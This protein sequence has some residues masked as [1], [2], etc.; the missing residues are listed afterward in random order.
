MDKLSQWARSHKPQVA[1]IAA[2]IIVV[3]VVAI[4][5]ASGAFATSAQQRGQET[6]TVDVTLNVTADSGWDE[7]STPAIAHIEGSDVDFYHA[8]TPD[9]EGNKGTSTVAL[10]EGDYTVS[11]VSPVNS[12]GSAFDIYDTGAPVDIT[13]DADAETAPAVDCPMTQIPADQ[14]TDEMLQD[15]IDQTKDAVE[16]GDETL[17]GDAGTDILDKLEGNVAQNP[18]ASDETKQEATDADKEVDVNKEPAQTTPPA[19]TDN[20][21]TGSQSSNTGNQSTSTGSSNS[22]STSTGNSGN[23][24]SSSSQPSQ[25]AH[26][27]TWVNHTA[28]RQVW[29][30]NWVD[31]PDYGTQQVQTGTRFVFSEDGYTTTSL[32]DAKAHAVALVKQGYVGNYHTEAIYETQTVQ[33]GSHKEDHGSYTTES[34]VDYVYCSSC[35]ARQ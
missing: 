16:N 23:S 33:T 8:V 11:F 30:S 5:V 3:I 1:A 2:A 22:G 7:N 12:D 32:S 15:I 25:P 18:N 17:K 10:A 6:R 14:V 31:V 26:T 35:G 34:Y 28:T 29:V 21:N 13:V 9:A 20:S 4:A 19:T 24:G 27:H